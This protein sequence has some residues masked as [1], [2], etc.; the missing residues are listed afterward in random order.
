MVANDEELLRAVYHP[1]HINSGRLTSTN[2]QIA[3]IIEPRGNGFSVTR[4]SFATEKILLDLKSYFEKK[5]ESNDFLG[6]FVATTA[7]LRSILV[8]VNGRHERLVCVVD[9]GIVNCEGGSPDNVAHALVIP[10]KFF[11]KN[12]VSHADMRKAKKE[13]KPYRESIIRCFRSFETFEEALKRAK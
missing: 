6:V 3:Q 2:M 10:S 5:R 8:D 12:A 13:L 1:D 11:R 4:S 7:E 9:D